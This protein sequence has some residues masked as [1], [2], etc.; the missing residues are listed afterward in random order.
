MSGAKKDGK[1]FV[2]QGVGPAQSD[3]LIHFT[4]RGENASFTPEVPEEFRQMTAQKR[5][6]S[7]LGSGQLI[8]RLYSPPMLRT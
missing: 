6:D 7:I 8:M 1:Q 3:T 5:L 4:S 2:L